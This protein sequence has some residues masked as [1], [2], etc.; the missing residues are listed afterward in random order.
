MTMP[1]PPPPPPPPGNG[2]PACHSGQKQ[3]QQKCSTKRNC[4]QSL[5]NIRNW[6]YSLGVTDAIPR[7]VKARMDMVT[8]NKEEK[9]ERETQYTIKLRQQSVSVAKVCAPSRHLS[10]VS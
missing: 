6:C 1:P 4:A 8:K 7:W 5:I 10:K 3:Q 9:K 2:W